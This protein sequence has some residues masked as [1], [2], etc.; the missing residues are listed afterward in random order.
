MFREASLLDAS[1]KSTIEPKVPVIQFL[2]HEIS[3]QWF[4][5]L[6][7]ADW[8]SNLWLNEGFGRFLE[9]H[10]PSLVSYII[11]FLCFNI[12]SYVKK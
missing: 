5:N 11:V 10:M 4:G 2:A 3:H 7:T 1:E 6:A 9:Y 8:W 12:D